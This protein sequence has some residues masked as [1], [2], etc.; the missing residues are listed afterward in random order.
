VTRRN[1][2]ELAEAPRQELSRPEPVVVDPQTKEEYVLVRRDVFIRLRAIPSDTEPRDTCPAIDTA[3]APG[4]ADPKMD[5][6]DRYEE[7]RP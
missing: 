2:I 5:D 3:F 6:C 7:L 1:L 4:W